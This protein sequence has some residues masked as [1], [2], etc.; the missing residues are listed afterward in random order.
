MGFTVIPNSWVTLLWMP[1]SIACTKSVL[2]LVTQR[3]EF[4]QDLS[5]SIPCPHS[6]WLLEKQG[7]T[8]SGL[9]NLVCALTAVLRSYET[10][11]R[12]PLPP[13]NSG[14][15]SGIG[16]KPII[17]ASFLFIFLLWKIKTAYQ[18]FLVSYKAHLE[19]QLVK[20]DY[21]CFSFCSVVLY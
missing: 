12:V 9:K 6:S 11:G 3:L 14:F 5:L 10:F 4:N 8:F 7:T 21:L 17:T 16:S 19:C 15:R 2:T 1:L 13:W 18:M 20:E